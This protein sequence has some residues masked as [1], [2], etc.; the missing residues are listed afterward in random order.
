MEEENASNAG[1]QAR[2]SQWT[3]NRE[4]SDQ[5]SKN[6]EEAGSQRCSK[7]GFWQGQEDT[8]ETDSVPLQKAQTIPQRLTKCKLLLLEAMAMFV[9]IESEIA[10]G[11]HTGDTT[12]GTEDQETAPEDQIILA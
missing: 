5:Q 2:G 3:R 1:N 6:Q 7:T 8:P 10:H 4:A 11:G 9:E 12:R